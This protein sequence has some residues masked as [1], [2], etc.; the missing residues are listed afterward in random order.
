GWPDHG[1]GRS[2]YRAERADPVRALRYRCAGL[3]PSGSPA[4]AASR[5]GLSG[6]GGNRSSVISEAGQRWGAASSSTGLLDQWRDLPAPLRYFYK[7]EM[8]LSEVDNL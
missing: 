7:E 5:L 2:R 3:A 1:R 8:R 4:C 6:S